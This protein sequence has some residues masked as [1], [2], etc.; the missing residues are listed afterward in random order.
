MKGTIE[1]EKETPVNSRT[2]QEL[3]RSGGKNE[4]CTVR[5]ANAAELQDRHEMHQK[6]HGLVGTARCRQRTR[7]GRAAPHGRLATRSEIARKPSTYSNHGFD[8]TGRRAS[9]HSSAYSPGPGSSRTCNPQIAS[10]KGRPRPK[11]RIV[12][13]PSYSFDSR[14]IRR[15]SQRKDTNLAVR[16]LRQSRLAS[17]ILTS[18]VYTEQV[19]ERRIKFAWVLLLLMVVDLSTAGVC[20]AGTFTMLDAP[21]SIS[22]SGSSATHGQ[23][24]QNLDD[25]GCFCCSLYVRPCLWIPECL[26]RTLEYRGMADCSA[27]I[28]GSPGGVDTTGMQGGNHETEDSEFGRARRFVCLLSDFGVLRCSAV[29][30]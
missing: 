3:I 5:E 7:R 17:H 21:A 6:T 24:V 22:L 16:R 20:T 12:S 30:G 27:P 13:C 8:W 9:S 11:P 19:S 10:P 23:P 1:T 18:R 14:R 15:F 25:D 26:L 2:V 4:A 29:V 28:T